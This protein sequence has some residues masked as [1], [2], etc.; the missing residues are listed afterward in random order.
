MN[1]RTLHLQCSARL[2]MIPME[3]T[4]ISFIYTGCSVQDFDEAHCAEKPG[5]GRH[6]SVY[7]EWNNVRDDDVNELKG[8]FRHFNRSDP[9]TSPL[10]T[11]GR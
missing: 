5:L 6:S 11:Q 4:R 8:L 7:E 2:L 1:L 10:N 9:Y 3:S